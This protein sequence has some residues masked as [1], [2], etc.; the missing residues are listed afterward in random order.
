MENCFEYAGEDSHELSM[1]FSFHHL[2]VDFM[3]NEKWV[4]VPTDFQKLKDIL[5]SWQIGMARI[6]P[7][8]QCSGAITISRVRFPDLVMKE[9]TG[10]S[11]LKCLRP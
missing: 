8:M 7:G 11:Q 9:N 6:M 2:K 4:L 10:K 3:G 5:F 1:V